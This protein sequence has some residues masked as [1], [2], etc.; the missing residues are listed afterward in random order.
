MTISLIMPDDER[1]KI[2]V[3]LPHKLKNGH[4][5][6][7]VIWIPKLNY[8]ARDVMEDHRGWVKQRYA[9]DKAAKTAWQDARVAAITDKT[10]VVPDQP[11]PLTE[12]E[13]MRD[14]A[15]RLFRDEWDKYLETQPAG[16]QQQLVR[17]WAQQSLV[18]PGESEASSNSSTDQE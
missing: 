13:Q 15:R 14:L 3:E 5:K 17:E 16:V 6:I 9:E 7:V 1:T 4:T 11:K 10:I 2:R 8:I 12:L 18:T